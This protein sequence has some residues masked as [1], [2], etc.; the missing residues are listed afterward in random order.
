MSSLAIGLV[1]GA[2]MLAITE[3]V[4]NISKDN[5]NKINNKAE[6]KSVKKE[7]VA[8]SAKYGFYTTREGDT[9]E[10]IAKTLYGCRECWFSIYDMNREKVKNNPWKRL[11]EGI[12]LK[13][14]LNLTFREKEEMKEKYMEWLR[15]VST[16]KLIPE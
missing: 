13:Y 6:R 1:V 7:R 3:L 2:F 8:A 4:F 14:K 16:G 15:K 10:K 12:K 11:K 9:L 5:A